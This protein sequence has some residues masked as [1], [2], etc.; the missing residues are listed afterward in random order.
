MINSALWLS[1]RQWHRI[2]E[3]VIAVLHCEISSCCH[4]VFTWLLQTLC[5]SHHLRADLFRRVV[6]TWVCFMSLLSFHMIL[7]PCDEALWRALTPICQ[8]VLVLDQLEHVFSLVSINKLPVTV[9]V[10]CDIDYRH[11]EHDIEDFVHR[12]NPRSLFLHF[13]VALQFL[14]RF[15]YTLPKII[16]MLPVRFHTKRS[17]NHIQSFFKTV[18][19]VRFMC[20][21]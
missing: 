10:Y 20:L 8:M 19:N 14:W 2:T 17:H 12:P 11:Y 7:P 13:V 6:F 9:P 16:F 3:A 15:F 21:S 5:K 18:S 1:G 4:T